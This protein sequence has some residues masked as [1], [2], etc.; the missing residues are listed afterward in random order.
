M[1]LVDK[2]G[3]LIAVDLLLENVM[4]KSIFH[5]ELV[6]RPAASVRQGVNRV[7][8]GRFDDGRKSFT[9]VDARSLGKATNNP[10]T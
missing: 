8:H 2:A 1:A 6:Y 10:C 7:D 3:G 4:E 5:V 9:K